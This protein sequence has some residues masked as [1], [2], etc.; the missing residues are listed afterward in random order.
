MDNN[1]LSSS[2]PHPHRHGHGNTQL[3]SQV[4]SY[5]SVDIY[6]NIY[7]SYISYNYICKYIASLYIDIPISY[8]NSLIENEYLNKDSVD[9][10]VLVFENIPNLE[11][12][13]FIAVEKISRR[14]EN[15]K[16]FFNTAPPG[17]NTNKLNVFFN[18]KLIMSFQ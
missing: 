10:K 13:P 6:H 4:I 11:I 7:L 9:L 15:I 17:F 1:Q 18:L 3:Y 2:P 16:S 8:K 12:E 14:K 5:C